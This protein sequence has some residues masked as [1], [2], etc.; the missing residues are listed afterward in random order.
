MVQCKTDSWMT[1]MLSN[2]HRGIRV[3][4]AKHV[5]HYCNMANTVLHDL[6]TGAVEKQFTGEGRAG[7]WCM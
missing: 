1:K 4:G 7:K 5:A 2:N 3:N 6:D